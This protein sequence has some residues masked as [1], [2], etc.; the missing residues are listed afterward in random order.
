MI[1]EEK[2]TNFANFL[3]VDNA[4][5]FVSVDGAFYC[6]RKGCENFMK[7]CAHTTVILPRYCFV[8]RD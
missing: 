8:T 1:S 6:R 3:S 7:K 4:L 2:K 5:R